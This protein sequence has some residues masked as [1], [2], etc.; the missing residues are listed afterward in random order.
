MQATIKVITDLGQVGDDASGVACAACGNVGPCRVSGNSP[1]SCLAARGAA[2]ASFAYA[3]EAWVI[4]AVCLNSR[5][6]AFYKQKKRV[7]P[8]KSF[9]C[10]FIFRSMRNR[11]AP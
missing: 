2:C 8:R 11:L 6:Q 5:S 3:S 1:C 10:D 4:Q 9:S 7:E